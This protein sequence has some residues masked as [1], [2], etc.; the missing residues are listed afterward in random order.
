[1]F[2]PVQVNE[3]S[4]QA[5]KSGRAAPVRPGEFPIQER[6]L[7]EAQIMDIVVKGSSLLGS[8]ISIVLLAGMSDHVKVTTKKP[9]CSRWG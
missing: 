9:W 3:N 2:V 5:L 4:V 6:E 8:E 1:M 7:Q